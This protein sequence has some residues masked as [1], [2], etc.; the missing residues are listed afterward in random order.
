ML[1]IG[2]NAAIFNKI[3]NGEEPRDTD[4]ICTFSELQA[5]L[6]A[7]R[8]D[9]TLK[10]SVPL[11][12]NHWHIV[13]SKGWNFEAEIAWEGSSGAALLALEGNEEGREGFATKEALL[14]LKLS[15]RY[16][17]DSPHYL[18]TMRDIQ[19]YRA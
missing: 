18:K 15:H 16:K 6:R 8:E 9:G 2:S 14:A 10:R 1:I 4:V 5:L 19:S 11:D 17:K 7:M 13:D 12:A 3:H